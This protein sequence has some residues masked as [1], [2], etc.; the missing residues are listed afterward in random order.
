[1]KL[2]LLFTLISCAGLEDYSEKE[3]K[4][5]IDSVENRYENKQNRAPASMATS[6]FDFEYSKVKNSCITAPNEVQIDRI[7][8][9]LSKK[10]YEVYNDQGYYFLKGPN[11]RSYLLLEGL[12]CRPLDF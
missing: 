3:D 11:G 8:N 6:M 1:M 7:T 4:N 5:S 12:A 9:R 10:G 2:L